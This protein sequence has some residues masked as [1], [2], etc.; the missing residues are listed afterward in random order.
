MSQSHEGSE[1]WR[2]HGRSRRQIHV[3]LLDG[4][5]NV[6]ADGTAAPLAFTVVAGGEK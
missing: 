3:L 2:H 6:N 1:R 4:M 5:H